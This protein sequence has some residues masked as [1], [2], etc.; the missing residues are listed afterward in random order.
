MFLKKARPKA[1]FGGGPIGT[2]AMAVLQVEQNSKAFGYPP[3]GFLTRIE[4]SL[5]YSMVLEPKIFPPSA[6]FDV[7]ETE[8]LQQYLYARPPPKSC[9]KELPISYAQLTA[10]LVLAGEEWPSDSKVPQRLCDCILQEIVKYAEGHNLDRRVETQEVIDSMLDYCRKR[11]DK[12]TLNTIVPIYVGGIASVATANPLPFWVA[13][14]GSIAANRHNIT[15]EAYSDINLAAI[16]D[17]MERAGDVEQ[18][19]LLKENH[20]YMN[21]CN[22]D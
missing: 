17:S 6:I 9:L 15:K 16:K 5:L 3:Q 21:N 13:Y 7:L 22:N 4:H 18:V 19:S 11:G 2:E 1:T 12:L 10:L 8:D 14:M 20:D